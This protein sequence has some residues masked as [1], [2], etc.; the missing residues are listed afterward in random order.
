MD[1]DNDIRNQIIIPDTHQDEFIKKCSNI[2]LAAF[3]SKNKNNLKIFEK[4]LS[5]VNYKNDILDNLLM[6][7]IRRENTRSSFDAIKLL[8]KYGADVNVIYDDSRSILIFCC[9]YPISNIKITELLIE[10]G[11]DVNIKYLTQ[12]P[13][14]YFI[15]YCSKNEDLQII[16]LLIRKTN[17][18][19]H[20]DEF[21]GETSLMKCFKSDINMVIRNDMNKTKLNRDEEL[22]LI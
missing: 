4:L 13:L 9:L 10:S 20:K 17:K 15:K 2:E 1:T 14:M 18:I 21:F 11:A 22:K 7:T 12:T 19:N 3:F 8:I 16:K 5:Q 6:E